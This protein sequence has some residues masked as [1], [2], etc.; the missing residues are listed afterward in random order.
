MGQLYDPFR[1]TF[2]LGTTFFPLAG[3]QYGILA[4]WARTIQTNENYLWLG[5]EWRPLNQPVRPALPLPAEPTPEP[6]P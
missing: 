5:V 6:Q 1:P 2:R 4:Q 3:N